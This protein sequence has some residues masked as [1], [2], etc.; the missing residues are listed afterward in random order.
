MEDF[1]TH[2]EK[3]SRK[4]ISRT[5]KKSGKGYDYKYKEPKPKAVNEKTE[6][7]KTLGMEH[8]ENHGAD[9]HAA[10]ELQLYIEND[11]QLYRQQFQPIVN[12]IKRKIKSGKLDESKLPQLFMYLVDNGAKKYQK[13]FG[14]EDFSFDKKTRQY[15]A[16]E[17]AKD[18]LHQIKNGEYD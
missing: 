15:V 2:F 14:N 12:N 1:L 6:K 3:A 8:P 13:E 10:N 5:P 11:G 7:R 18:T 16:R 17:M 9:K 4:Y